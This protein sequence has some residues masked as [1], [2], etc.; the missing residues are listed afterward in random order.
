MYRANKMD[1]HDK[2]TRSFNMSQIKNKNTKPEMLIR[3]GLHKLGFRYRLHDSNL[4][5]NPDL[6]FPKYK[7]IIFVNGCF[8]HAHD[9]HLFKW[10][11]SNPEF[12][13]K[14]I[15][16]NKVRDQKNIRIYKESGWKVMTIWQ[17]A[18]TGKTKKSLNA[19][20]GTSQKW[21]KHSTDNIEIRGDSLSR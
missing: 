9:C 18:L 14:K 3:S 8:W 12:W 21:L 1:V 6:V 5:G 20:L 10:P 19:V 4:P 15:L 11:K 13:R 7:A 2:T 16:G 17:C